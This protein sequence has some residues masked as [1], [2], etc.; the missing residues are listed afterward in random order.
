[1]TVAEIDA[2]LYLPGHP[3]TRLARALRIPALSPGWKGSLQALLDQADGDG[4]RTGN[5]GLTAA[6]EPAAGLARIPPAA[7]STAIDQREP[8]RVLA[9]AGRPG[10]RAAAGGAARPVPHLAAAAASRTGRR[11]SAA[12]RCRA[13]PVRRST[14][15]A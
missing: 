6:A 7:G 12:T 15:S 3:A 9:V 5:A 2:L 1:M 4:R 11:S 13:G 14:G 10:W 8:Q